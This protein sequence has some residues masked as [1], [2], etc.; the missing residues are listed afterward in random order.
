MA[1]TAKKQQKS[2]RIDIVDFWRFFAAIMIV[3]FHMPCIGG[4]NITVAFFVEF[5]FMLTGFFIFKHFQK[6]PFVSAKSEQKAK[7]A[8]QYT[9]KRFKSLLPYTIPIVIICTPVVAYSYYA[10]AHYQPYAIGML[11]RIFI[12]P[13]LLPSQLEYDGFRTIGPLWYLSVMIFF[14]P[15]ICYIAQT[16]KINIFV[17]CMIPICWLYLSCFGLIYSQGINSPLVCVRGLVAMLLGGVIFYLVEI[18]KEKKISNLKRIFF[19]VAEIALYLLAAFIR[20]YYSKPHYVAIVMLFLAL[21]ITLSGL[22]YTS[23]IKSKLFNFLGA[24]SLPLFMWHYGIISVLQYHTSYGITRRYVIV[25]GLSIAL[26]II[27]YVIVQKIT[28]ARAAKRAKL[29][30]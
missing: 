1:E 26:S 7:N 8:I 14:M 3:L 24:I 29:K 2:A 21:V 11:K 9:W 18:I 4:A 20:F 16:K 28:S 22:S 25:F 12:E 19:T 27:H 6:S 10:Q 13:F 23:K 15:I 5:F 17:M 30:A